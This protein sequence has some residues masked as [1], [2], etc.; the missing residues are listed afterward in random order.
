MRQL[1]KPT[2]ICAAPARVVRDALSDFRGLGDPNMDIVPWFGRLSPCVLPSGVA[3]YYSAMIANRLRTN[4]LTVVVLCV[5][6]LPTLV[7]QSATGLR[8]YNGEQQQHAQATVSFPRYLTTGHFIEA[9]F[10]NWESEFLQMGLYV[11]LTVRLRQ[12]GSAESKSF[13]DKEPVDEDPSSH[14]SAPDAPWPVRQGGWV[15]SIYKYSLS[16]AFFAL[17]FMSAV[18]HAWGGA[19]E[20]SAEEIAHGGRGVSAANY[21]RT[22]QFWFESLQ[23]WQSEFLSIVAIVVFTI[24]LRQIGSPESKPVA[25]P[26]SQTGSN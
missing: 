9:T 20:H 15:L 21:V 26:H 14:A 6:F 25:A 23:N 4:G 17:F 2:T 22:S 5:L 11:V 16:I 19:R 12:R 7:G 8:V 10:E 1:R 13:D 24:F 3:G 18:L